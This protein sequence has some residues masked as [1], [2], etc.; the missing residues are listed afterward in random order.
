[1]ETPAASDEVAAFADQL[2]EELGEGP[3][4]DTLWDEDTV[5][6]PDLVSD[7]RWSAWGAR[8]TEE[9]GTRSVV[10]FRLFTLKNVLGALTMYSEKPDAFDCQ[11]KAEAL[12][13]AAHIAVAV[14]AAQQFEQYETALDSRTI[15]AQACGIVMKRYDLDAA[16]AFALLVRLSSTQN[17]KLRDLAAELVFTRVLPLSP[18]S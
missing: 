13:L 18:G 2:Q 8:L 11:D 6:V 12:A 15:T 10:T 7:S 14:I 9:T 1:M 5:H 16:R 17:V 4:L 3:A